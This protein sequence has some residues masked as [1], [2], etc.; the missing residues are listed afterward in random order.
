MTTS[1]TLFHRK[2]TSSFYLGRI[3]NDR[4]RRLS[5]K[6]TCLL[7]CARA[8]FA[9]H[10]SRAEGGDGF[11]L[12][13][14]LQSAS[15]RGRSA[16]LRSAA[17]EQRENVDRDKENLNLSLRGRAKQHRL[18]YT[19][20][21]T[22]V[23]K[24]R[25]DLCSLWRSLAW[26]ALDVATESLANLKAGRNVAFVYGR[27]P[28][29]WDFLC[30]SCCLHHLSS[31]TPG[32]FDQTADMGDSSVQS[33]ETQGI[34]IKYDF[35]RVRTFFQFFYLTFLFLFFEFVVGNNFRRRPHE[36]LTLLSCLKGMSLTVDDEAPVSKEVEGGTATISMN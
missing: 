14:T 16:V 8:H 36:G 28:K 1:D 26:N 23:T 10:R 32:T 4:M 29:P 7:T 25:N 3:P 11:F 12:R 18:A 31:Q 33:E 5:Q 21:R 2:T 9:P 17:K 35:I 27:C 34:S 6:E 20:V 22:R 19:D 24:N 30:L 13:L 15:Q